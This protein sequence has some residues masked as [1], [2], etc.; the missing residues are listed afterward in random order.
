MAH[1][2]KD[3]AIHRSY[4]IPLFI[5]EPNDDRTPSAGTPPNAA[6]NLGKIVFFYSIINVRK[7]LLVVTIKYRVDLVQ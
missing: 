6:D 5:R 7:Y 4:S 1:L 2:I 3:Q